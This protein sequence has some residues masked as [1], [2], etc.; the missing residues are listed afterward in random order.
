[1]VSVSLSWHVRHLSPC[2]LFLW[3]LHD[4]VIL[5]NYHFPSTL[6][7][8]IYKRLASLILKISV[9]ATC[10][11]VAHAS[12]DTNLTLFSCHN[13]LY[14]KHVFPVSIHV[15][16]SNLHRG[17]TRP[18]FHRIQ[19]IVIPENRSLASSHFLTSHSILATYFPLFTF[20]SRTPLPPTQFLLPPTHVP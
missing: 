20:S 11:P 9:T 7:T 19:P 14:S 3:L 4:V 2:Q 18:L 5:S 13:N 1:M 17:Y 8:C 15:C 10:P 12:S 6:V 16:H